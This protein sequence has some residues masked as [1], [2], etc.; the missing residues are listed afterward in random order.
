MQGWGFYEQFSLRVSGP[1][2]I[3]GGFLKCLGFPHRGFSSPAIQPPTPNKDRIRLNEELS[4]ADVDFCWGDGIGLCD[5]SCAHRVFTSVLCMAM[6]VFRI[7][8]QDIPA[9]F[10][11]LRGFL[12]VRVFLQ[13]NGP[14]HVRQLCSGEFNLNSKGIVAVGMAHAAVQLNGIVDQRW[15]SF[16]R[17]WNSIIREST[18]SYSCMRLRL[19]ADYRR[20]NCAYTCAINHGLTVTIMDGMLM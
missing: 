8:H 9:L 16:H 19:C 5:K 4:G 7:V 1:W 18:A 20:K 13:M 10:F 15:L 12:N 3:L 17:T 14:T 11:F 2:C 6:L